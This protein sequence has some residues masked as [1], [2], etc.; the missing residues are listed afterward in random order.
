MENFFANNLAAICPALVSYNYR[1]KY[2]KL[3]T[4]N[5]TTWVSTDFNK[6]NGTRV[7]KVRDWLDGRLHI[8][9]VYFNLNRA[10]P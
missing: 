6:F 7:N 10:M 1:S 2:L 8:L 5:D 9:D 4:E 3:A